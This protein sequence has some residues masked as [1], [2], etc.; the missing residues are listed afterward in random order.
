MVEKLKDNLINIQ[1]DNISV[2]WIGDSVFEI[3]KSWAI[4]IYNAYDRP[5][6]LDEVVSWHSKEWWEEWWEQVRESI[7]KNSIP[8]MFIAFENWVPVWTSLLVFE[9]MMTRKDLSPWM[10]WVLVHPEHRGKWVGTLLVK[11]AMQKSKELWIKTLWLYT[12]SAKI[13][14]ETCGWEYV[15]EEMYLWENVTIMKYNP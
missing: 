10:G 5:D 11:K 6:V 13:L 1:S 7:N 2:A 15:S 3:T 8:M 14:Y 9:D 12:A 4:E